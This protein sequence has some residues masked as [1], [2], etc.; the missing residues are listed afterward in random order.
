MAI[1]EHLCIKNSLSNLSPAAHK[2]SGCRHEQACQLASRPQHSA[3][4]VAHTDSH[5]AYHQ[6]DV[7]RTLCQPSEQLSCFVVSD[8]DG[9]LVQRASM[10]I[11]EGMPRRW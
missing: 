3:D 2:H 7:K 4:D 5:G 6:M 9:Q 1:K 10:I 11:S 8:V